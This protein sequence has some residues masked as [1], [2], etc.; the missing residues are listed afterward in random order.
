MK[1]L[2]AEVQQSIYQVC[3]AFRGGESGEKHR[4]EF[5][6]LEWYRIGYSLEELMVDL[7]QLVLHTAVTLSSVYGSLEPRIP[8]QRTTY[9]ALFQQRYD[10]CPH[11]AS[12]DE[13]RRLCEAHPTDHLDKNARRADLLDALFSMGVEPE[14]R[15][16]ILVSDYPASQ[17]AL[18][19]LKVDDEGCEVANR[20]EFYLDGM[21]IANA[22][23][24][25]TDAGELSQRFDANNATRLQLGKPQIPDD[26]TLLK[27][28]DDL[29]M[30]AGAALGIDRLLM[31]LLAEKDIRRV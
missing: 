20:F 15:S 7:E 2:L 29:P 12:D 19:E 11:R 30:C 14:L 6:M 13:L 26:S 25:L 9:K 31:A 10:V 4:S 5:Q 28:M 22:Y 24:E 16:P 8:F 23:Q 1:V 17:A 18:A 3:P 27:A 21:E